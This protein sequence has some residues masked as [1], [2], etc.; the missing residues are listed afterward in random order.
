[1][2]KGKIWSALPPFILR[3]SSISL[4]THLELAER[5]EHITIQVSQVP[6]LPVLID[7]FQ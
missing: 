4:S 3:K 7:R 6:N 1:M 2:M 5:G